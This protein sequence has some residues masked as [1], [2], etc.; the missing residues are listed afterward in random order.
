M[1][2]RMPCFPSSFED[3]RCLSEYVSGIAQPSLFQAAAPSS[4]S[5]TF[6]VAREWIFPQSETWSVWRDPFV[7]HSLHQAYI[8]SI[9][10]CRVSEVWWPQGGVNLLSFIQI[11]SF[12]GKIDSWMNERSFLWPCW[13]RNV[14][15]FSTITSLD[16]ILCDCSKISRED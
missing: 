4:A 6:L 15:S 3:P 9:P 5:L 16:L 12:N 14:G 13:R 2:A 8:N 10:F 7:Q 11:F 1:V